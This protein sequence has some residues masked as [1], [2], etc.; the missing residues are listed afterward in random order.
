MVIGKILIPA[1]NLGNL[2]EVDVDP[3]DIDGLMGPGA[4]DFA[5]GVG[6]GGRGA[7][8]EYDLRGLG[9]GSCSSVAWGRGGR[10]IEDC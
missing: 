7:E 3:P 10:S 8:E 5:I 4:L 1:K 2:R 9:V 6:L